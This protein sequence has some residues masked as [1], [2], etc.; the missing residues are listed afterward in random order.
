MC[1]AT[2]REPTSCVHEL[3]TLLHLVKGFYPKWSSDKVTG[4]AAEWAVNYMNVSSSPL[5]Y[6]APHLALSLP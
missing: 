4:P 5:V 1:L 3:L 2:V 6:P